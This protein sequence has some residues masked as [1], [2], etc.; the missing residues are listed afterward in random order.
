[1]LLIL[2]LIFKKYVDFKIFKIWSLRPQKMRNSAFFEGQKNQEIRNSLIF[3][4][5]LKKITG[6]LN[7]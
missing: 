7:R 4:L 3:N 2:D 6:T 1:M 5:K